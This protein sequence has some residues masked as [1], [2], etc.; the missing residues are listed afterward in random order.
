MVKS[1]EASILYNGPVYIRLTGGQN[2]ETIYDKDYD[3]KIG[4]P[5]TLKEGKEGII[6]S[7]GSITYNCMQAIK[8]L[9]DHTIWIFL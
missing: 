7:N 1:L 5:V 9:K 6:L 4:T 2:S 3:F 8:K